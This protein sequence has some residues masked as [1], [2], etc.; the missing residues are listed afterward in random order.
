M[1]AK[2]W[3]KEPIQFTG[4]N[5]DELPGAIEKKKSSG[6]KSASLDSPLLENTENNGNKIKTI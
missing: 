1:Q 3:T 6:D 2:V 5:L 4:N